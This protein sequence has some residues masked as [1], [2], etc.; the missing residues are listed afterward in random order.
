MIRNA[1]NIWEAFT[2]DPESFADEEEASS[3]VS[4]QYEEFGK[5]NFGL[6]GPLVED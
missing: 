4:S 2:I 3:E 5:S 1:Q 6:V